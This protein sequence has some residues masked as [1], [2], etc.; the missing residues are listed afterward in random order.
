MIRWLSIDEGMPVVSFYIVSY[1]NFDRAPEEVQPIFEA[2][3]YA[4]D[5]FRG[6]N[7]FVR[8]RV[9]G[10]LD[11][12]P[13]DIADNIRAIDNSG[14]AEG[15]LVNLL[16]GYSGNRDRMQAIDACRAADEGP[17]EENLLKHSSLGSYPI[18]VLVRTGGV[19]RLSDG[20]L[21]GITQTR[22][23]PIDKLFAEVTRKDLIKVLDD[24][25]TGRKV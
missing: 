2:V 9:C 21:V 25:R 10:R 5:L 7:G 8:Y 18:D 15:N 11:R 20:P 22:M 23:Y 16:I 24:F 3:D 6:V 12:F 14:N 19:V 17:T 13:E 4:M 1:Y